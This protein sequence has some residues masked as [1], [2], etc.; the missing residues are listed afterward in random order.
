MTSPDSRYPVGPQPTP[1]TVSAAEREQAV[2]AIAALSAELR[3]AVAGLNDTQLGTPYRDGGWTVRQV[4][5]H[6]ADSHM[7]AYVRVKLALTEDRPTISPYD[8]DAWVKLADMTL[9]AEVSLSLLDSL[10]TRW[11]AALHHL[12]EAQWAREYIHPEYGRASSMAQVAVSYAWH[13]RHHTGHIL[14]LREARGW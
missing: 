11:V 5:H 14:Q 4:V 2:R 3:S 1:E 9:P 12:D 10:H 13:G 7:N 6:V 8:Q